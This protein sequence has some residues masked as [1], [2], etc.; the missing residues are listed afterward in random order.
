MKNKWL[1]KRNDY[2]KQNIGLWK[3]KGLC[4]I[5]DYEKENIGLWKINDYEKY[6]WLW[7][8]YKKWWSYKPPTCLL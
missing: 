4:S 2:A 7:K 5:N 6:K 1:W 3:I 8:I